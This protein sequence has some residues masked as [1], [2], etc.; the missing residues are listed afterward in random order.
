[1]SAMRRDIP[2]EY[3]D[4]V[5]TVTPTGE[6]DITGAEPLRT[7]FEVA[8]GFGPDRIRVRMGAVTFIDSTGLSALVHGWRLASERGIPLTVI[9]P[10]SAV[11][12]ILTITRLDCLI[13]G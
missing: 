4:G 11:V 3:V 9:E 10:G 2:V 1:M 8:I 7:A 12:R 5:A 6:I 13:E